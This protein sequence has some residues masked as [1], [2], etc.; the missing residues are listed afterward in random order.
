MN[1]RVYFSVVLLLI[2]SMTGAKTVTWFS[3]ATPPCHIV[4]GVEAG[5]GYCDL[6]ITKAGSM[7]PELT[8]NTSFVP[9]TRLLNAVK[10]NELAC[11]VMLGL[12]PQRETFLHFSDP[13]ISSMP[14]IVVMRANDW[15]LEHLVN[16]DGDI[17]IQDLVT[18][19]DLIWG[20][21]KAVLY[22]KVIQD[23][24]AKHNPA[25]AFYDPDVD[26][27]AILD[28]KRID[29][30]VRAGIYRPIAN[31]A[32]GTTDIKFIPIKES[33]AQ[34]DMR[35]SCSANVD[36]KRIIDTLNTF[37]RSGGKSEFDGYFESWLH[38]SAIAYYRSM[39]N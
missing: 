29:Y 28:S 39:S 2:S 11:S 3:V 14:F 5:K 15:R 24:I 1:Y 32:E 30:L 21:P 25:S 18:Q 38:P 36:G 31:R 7:M 23:S 27:F 34:Q 16:E 19:K 9:P 12:T 17:S 8:H 33:K 37:L 35:F 10:S 6:S 20:R 4:N 22:P 26:E 13:V